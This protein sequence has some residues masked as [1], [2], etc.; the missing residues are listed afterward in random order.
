MTV[1]LD[2]LPVRDGFRLRGTE[3]TRLETFTDAAF[4]FAATV[5]VIAGGQ[6]PDSF[7]ALMRSLQDIPAFAASFAVI[8]MFW[9]GHLEWSRRYGLE[10]GPSI[11]YSG[12]LIFVVLTYVVPLKV[13]FG[14][15]FA[16]MSG[17]RLGQTFVVRDGAQMAD[18][19]VLYGL[20]YVAMCAILAVLNLHARRR[21]DE[22]RLDRTERLLTRLAI[23]QWSVAAG[24]GVVSVLVAALAPARIG[25]WAGFAYCAMAIVMPLWGWTAH[26]RF[27]RLGEET[28]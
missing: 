17:G 21:A 7:E 11:V 2:T 28:A 22:L 1:D 20:G 13:I 18:I 26:R 24:P 10:D 19:F 8:L 15:M 6:V 27:R 12:L 3:M 23:E 5:L 4:A 25:V 14:Q 16:W 9:N